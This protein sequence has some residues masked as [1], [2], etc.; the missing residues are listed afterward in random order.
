MSQIDTHNRFYKTYS[1]AMFRIEV[2]S[3]SQKG[4]KRKLNQDRFVI[5]ELQDGI[6]AALADGMGGEP[7]GEKASAIAVSGI[8]AVKQIP[9]NREIHSLVKTFHEIDQQILT[10]SKTDHDAENMGTTLTALYISGQSAY[11]THVGDTRIYLFRHKKM[12]QVTSDHTF[13]KFLLDE[14]EITPDQAKTHYSQHILEQCMG[15][16]EINPET[17]IMP[18]EQNDLIL[19][20]SDGLHKPLETSAI[21]SILNSRGSLEQKCDQLIRETQNAKGN[22]DITVVL[23]RLFNP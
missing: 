11:W 8:N 9:E 17:G 22:D 1:S 10:A 15:Q 12:T 21:Q 5:T 3:L 16:G 4:M 14:G 6:V 20:S 7:G 2:A 18:L 13:A 19:L 23:I